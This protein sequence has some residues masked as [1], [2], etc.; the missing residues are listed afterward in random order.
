[1]TPYELITEK[2]KEMMKE[3]IN[4][5]VIPEDSR[6]IRTHER[7]APMIDILSHWDD[8]KS[9]LLFPLFGNKLIL[10]YPITI[11]YSSQ[12]LHNLLWD[13]IFSKN[14]NH[15][16]R[17]IE[18]L[19]HFTEW[20]ILSNLNYVENKYEGKTIELTFDSY[21]FRYFNLITKP[22]TF[23]FINGMKISRIFGK[24]AELAGIPG[25]E[26]FRCQYSQLGNYKTKNETLCL[27]IHPMDYMTMSDNNEDWESCMSWA[28]NGEYRVG[29]IE[30]MNSP[31]V[32]VAYLKSHY[33]LSWAGDWNSKKWR[34][35]YICSNNFVRSITGY[36]YKDEKLTKLVL[37][38]IR[39]L[40]IK[41]INN[42]GMIHDFTNDPIIEIRPTESIY[43]VHTY[44]MY[45]DTCYH[46]GYGFGRL[47]TN[48]M[49]NYSG[50]ATCMLCGYEMNNIQTSQ[51]ACNNCIEEGEY[52]D[53]CDRLIPHS[54]INYDEYD[55]IYCSDCW[56][57]CSTLCEEC[58]CEIIPND[59]RE[60]TIQVNYEEDKDTES[61]YFNL[62]FDCYDKIC[63]L[64]EGRV[65]YGN[66]LVI[67]EDEIQVIKRIIPEVGRA[68]SL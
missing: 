6:F 64:F 12:E 47:E 44:N 68:L 8:A 27:S 42:G 26:E 51:I 67:D 31:Y 14:S 61:W 57:N 37:E 38:K 36:P 30:M 39:E 54:E 10:E 65:E 55:N 60:L 49:F 41:L 28:Q 7:S 48:G 23:K 58:G 32:I 66:R 46:T 25:Y 15:F 1:M 22:F 9:E 18:N 20:S 53:R 16:V 34:E 40:Y 5:F 35:L 52:C 56:T 62:C 59:N 19:I 4:N 29:T 50:P 43:R 17:I 3:Y 13:E 11:E 45:N 21:E 24:I 33:N 63:Q 2:E